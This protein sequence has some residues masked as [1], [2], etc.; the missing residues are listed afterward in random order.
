ML[1]MFKTWVQTSVIVLA[2]L[3]SCSVSAFAQGDIKQLMQQRD[4]QIKTL[5]GAKGTKH[6]PEQT[7]KLKG[8]INDMVDFEAMAKTAL[9]D[10]WNEADEP[11]RKEFVDLFARIIRDQ[12]LAKPDMYRA[13]VAYD[14]IKVTGKSAEV[15]TTATFDNVRMPVA[16]QMAQKAGGWVITDIIIDNVSTAASYQK[17]FQNV[18]RRRGFDALLT[19]LR[20]RADRAQG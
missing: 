17:S 19:S 3:V 12:S 9:Q 15:K 5:I 6:T 2:L 8:I 7:E 16:Y 11:Q 4:K 18:I 10:T 13:E 20:N 14:D 1:I